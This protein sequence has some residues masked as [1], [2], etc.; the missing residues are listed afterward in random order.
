MR[1]LVDRFCKIVCHRRNTV[2]RIPK[3]TGHGDLCR[4]RLQT[5]MESDNCVSSLTILSATGCL[6]VRPHLPWGARNLETPSCTG[7]CPGRPARGYT[8][9]RRWIQKPGMH[10]AHSANLCRHR[11]ATKKSENATSLCSITRTHTTTDIPTAHNEWEHAAVI[12]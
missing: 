6:V 11:T 10:C 3:F 9:H 5:A 8:M 2:A 7:T 12:L 1:T 4:P